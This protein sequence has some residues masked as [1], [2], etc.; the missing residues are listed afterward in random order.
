MHSLKFGCLRVRTLL[1]FTHLHVPRSQLEAQVSQLQGL[2][3]CLELLHHSSTHFHTSACRITAHLTF[4]HLRVPRSQLE[5]QVSQLQGLK[6]CLEAELMDVYA[7]RDRL[8]ELLEQVGWCIGAWAHG[9]MRMH[10]SDSVAHTCLHQ[11]LVGRA[12]RYLDTP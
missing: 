1:T 4:T 9:C 12:D 11:G 10:T 8:A 2:K 6:E 3:D 7:D 5:A